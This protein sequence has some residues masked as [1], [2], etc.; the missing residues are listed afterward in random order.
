MSELLVPFF[1]FFFF[2]CV[3]SFFVFCLA[4]F[5]VLFWIGEGF[6]SDSPYF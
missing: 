1:F 2:Y 6:D 3:A 4:C 5:I